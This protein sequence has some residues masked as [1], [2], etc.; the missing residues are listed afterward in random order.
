[1]PE[2]SA[3][4]PSDNSRIETRNFHLQP[5]PPGPRGEGWLLSCCLQWHCAALLGTLP[6]S[7]G[8]TANL[9]SLRVTAAGRFFAARCN[10]PT[11]YPYPGR[12][13]APCCVAAST[14]PCRAT[15]R[16][17]LRQPAASMPHAAVPGRDG[18]SE[19]GAAGDAGNYS[20]L[21]AAS[22]RTTT[23]PSLPPPPFH[24]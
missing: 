22:H 6:L 5:G 14:L 10:T 17:G 1:M 24:D 13:C 19:R 18:A 9:S 12:G 20:D 23:R 21:R 15:R 2:S 7:R 4:L 16:E 3:G 11:P 8:R